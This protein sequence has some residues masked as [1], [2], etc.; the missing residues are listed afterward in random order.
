M[1]VL[2]SKAFGNSNPK[3]FTDVIQRHVC[4]KAR[5][6][7]RILLC[8]STHLFFKC[9]LGKLSQV[10]SRASVCLVIDLSV[11]LPFTTQINSGSSIESSKLIRTS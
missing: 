10:F 2:F 7:I 5:E 9:K 6:S 11:P 4:V 1:H 8:P 3:I